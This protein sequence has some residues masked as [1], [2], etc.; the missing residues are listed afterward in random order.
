ML[1][2]ALDALERRCLLHSQTVTGRLCFSPLSPTSLVQRQALHCTLL[3]S[4][5]FLL[6]GHSLDA[7]TDPSLRVRSTRNHK[8]ANL[9]AFFS[10]ASHILL[11]YGIDYLLLTD[12]LPR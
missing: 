11:E 3:I 6:L 9:L 10:S 8:P 1:S 7:H 4:S 2:F 12:N 5:F